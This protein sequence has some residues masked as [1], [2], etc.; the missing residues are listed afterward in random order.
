MKSLYVYLCL[1]IFRSLLLIKIKSQSSMSFCNRPNLE[2]SEVG[3]HALCQNEIQTGMFDY[4]KKSYIWK[5]VIQTSL[6]CAPEINFLSLLS[7]NYCLIRQVQMPSGAEYLNGFDLH[8]LR[9]E[10]INEYHIAFT[11]EIFLVSTSILHM[12]DG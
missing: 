9:M 10:I 2:L 11:K 6:Q 5:M 1:Y 4:P 3:A 12:I 8:V 7:L